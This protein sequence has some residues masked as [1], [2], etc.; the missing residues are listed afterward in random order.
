MTLHR[1]SLLSL[2]ALAPVAGWAQPAFPR[3]PVKII[4]NFAVGG[5]LDV[6]ARVLAENLAGRVGQP[7]IVEN[8][9]GANGNLGVQALL[10]AEPDGHTLLFT[11]ENAITVSPH[12]YNLSYDPLADMM[13]VSL[14][15]AFEQVLTVPGSS[16]L[17]SVEEFV[18]KARQG[19]LS[20]ASAGNGSPGHLAF[21]AF[22]G[23]A[24]IRGTHVPYRGNAPAVNDL[25]AGHVD[26]AF[27]VIGG[28]RPHLQSGKLRALAVSGSERSP[29]LPQVPTLAQAGYPGFSL[30]YGYVVTVPK[31]TPAQVAGL[32]QDQLRRSLADPA[33]AERF[34]QLDTRM[35]NGDAAAARKWL[36]QSS[37]RWK[38]TLARGAVKVE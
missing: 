14:V 28:V 24:G 13:P 35:I 32:W 8:V 4:V 38:T 5:P 37:S 3:K 29:E 30:S 9:T 11:A 31:G 25:L 10:R 2:A 21:L 22:A 19:K 27:V 26:A 15:G 36:E 7:V 16:E 23:R 20:Y 1:R 12:I 17:R 33:V 18:R 34:R 6:M